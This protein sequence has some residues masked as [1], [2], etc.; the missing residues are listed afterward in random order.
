M[1]LNV[2]VC[3][4]NTFFKRAVGMMFG[5]GAGVGEC[6]AIAPCNDIHTCFMRWN[7]DVA[8]VDACGTVLMVRHNVP[9]FKRMRCK[10]AY[11]AI[12]RRSRS[13]PWLEVDQHFYPI[14]SVHR[15]VSQQTNKENF[16]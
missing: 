3:F 10:G 14:N 12:E 5:A 9:P 11:A 6:L 7:I 8:F 13:A 16:Q 15:H 1:Q 2:N 4:A